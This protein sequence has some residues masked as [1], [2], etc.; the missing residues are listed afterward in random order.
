M[1]FVVKNTPLDMHFNAT[2]IV[3][4]NFSVPFDASGKIFPESLK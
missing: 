4:Y 3:A 2:C 1:D